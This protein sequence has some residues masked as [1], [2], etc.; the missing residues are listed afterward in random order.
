MPGSS[1]RSSPTWPTPSPATTR[2]AAGKPPTAG[3]ADLTAVAG[4]ALAGGAGRRVGTDKA[5][6]VVAG[7]ALARTAA[8][9]LLAAGAARVVAVGG[10]RAGLEALGLEVV[11]DE[12]PG[13]GPLGAIL[14]ALAATDEDVV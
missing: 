1:T 4:A 2:A 6:L 13:E 7:R 12:H 5:L 14:T 11:V 9:A 8:D 3:R 10:D